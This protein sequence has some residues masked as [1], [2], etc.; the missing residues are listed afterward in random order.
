MVASSPRRAHVPRAGAVD[1]DVR[2]EAPPVGGGDGG[3]AGP[4]AH[5]AHGDTGVELEITRL[6][7]R[8]QAGV[9]GQDA[10]CRFE[11]DGAPGRDPP[12]PS[13]RLGGRQ[14]LGG[15]TRG[16]QRGRDGSERGSLTERHLARGVEQPAPGGGLERQ[17]EVAGA[18]RHLDV[19]RVGVAEPE[20]AGAALGARPLV[21]DGGGGLEDEDAPAPPRQRPRRAQAEEPA[22]DD[23]AATVV[24]HGDDL[25]NAASK[26]V[27]AVPG[28]RGVRRY[29][30]R[31]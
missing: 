1:D 6:A 9:R 18:E 28:A 29:A 5:R 8:T 12:A 20:D 22:A 26:G 14:P 24:G 30:R 3:A 19:E 10:G 21:A 17:P 13:R 15:R 25:R 31:Q 16:R 23:D 7:Q 4:V 11:E 2:V 27:P